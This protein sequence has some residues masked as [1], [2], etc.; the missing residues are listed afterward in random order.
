ME[1]QTITPL[2]LKK[3]NEEIIEELKINVAKMLSR[4]RYNVSN[5]EIA[6][7]INIDESKE[8]LEKYVSEKVED[9]GE[10]IYEYKL[11]TGTSCVVK[12]LFE[13]LTGIGKNT[14]IA[15]FLGSYP[16]YQKIIIASDYNA[17]VS[18]ILS[19]TGNI[20]KISSL[21]IDIL[22]NKL[23]PKFVHLTLDQ[24]EHVKLAWCATNEDLPKIKYS[25]PVA[26]YL[27]LKKNTVIKIVRY[28]ITSGESVAYKII[29]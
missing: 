20:F 3:T 5:S 15:E 1:E 19:K 6:P 23:Q 16:K 21:L 25:D 22:K 29:N 7:L 24:M 8:S 28:S 14:P 12:I 2:L 27:G 18:E 11:D 4:R 26:R 10:N 9:I 17:K 13:K